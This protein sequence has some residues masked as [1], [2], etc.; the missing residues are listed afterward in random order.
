MLN[1]TFLQSKN[2]LWEAPPCCSKLNQKDR[3]QIKKLTIL[4]SKGIGENLLNSFL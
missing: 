3:K 1:I 2:Y 4:K